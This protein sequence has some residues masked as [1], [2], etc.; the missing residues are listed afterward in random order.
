MSKR[1]IIS[2][3]GT[4]GH[5]FP[6]ISIANACKRRWPQC[7]ILFVGAETKMEMVRV[8]QA[9]Y[10]IIGLPVSGL[11]RSI[12]IKNVKVL[13]DLIRSLFKARRIIKKFNPDV[14]I[15]VGGYASFP[16][17]MA[18]GWSR[19]PIVLQEQNSY[20][21][22][23]NK[24]LAKKAEVVCVAYKNME[25][26]FT[27]AKVVLTGNP[28]RETIVNP[29]NTSDAAVHFELMPG[30]ET[31]LVLGGSLG[32]RSINEGV[33]NGIKK[34]AENPERQVVWQTGSYYYQEMS[35]LVEFPN[36]KVVD[37]I[38]RMDFAYQ[39]ADVIISRAGAGTISELCLV[40]K[41]TILVPSKNVAED[42]QTKNAQALVD[43]EAVVMVEDNVAK[44]E[45]ID[46]AITLLDD[47]DKC[48]RLKENIVKLAIKNSDDLIVDE[49]DRVII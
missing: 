27:K 1:I 37:F 32:A 16:V 47:R 17:L 7:E 39:L 23:A 44:K 45:L 3:G 13:I 2:G 36:V 6:A 46:A 12:T 19:I 34:I 4:G 40:G 48:H 8:P 33:L 28:V 26:F 14:A 5:I 31:I 20:A 38:S 35:Q 43:E 24:F 29:V 49:I 25:R 10:E 42:H 30:K 15:G 18:A 11:K 22:V 21:G 41:P 9:G